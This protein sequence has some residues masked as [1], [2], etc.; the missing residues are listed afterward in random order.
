MAEV[1]PRLEAEFG[2]SLAPRAVDVLTLGEL[3]WHDCHGETSPPEQV[4]DDILVLA[5]GDL[6]RLIEAMRL[7]VTDS[8]DLRLA[9]DDARRRSSH[10]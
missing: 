2:T 4:L 9:A 3:A 8:R 7:A 5:D 10:T 1:M 6:G